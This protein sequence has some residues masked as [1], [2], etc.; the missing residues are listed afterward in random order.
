MAYTVPQFRLFQD[1]EESTAASTSSLSAVIIAPQYNVHQYNDGSVPSYITSSDGKKTQYNPEGIDS[2]AYPNKTFGSQVDTE[3]VHI[4]FENAPAVYNSFSIGSAVSDATATIGGE[5]SNRIST[6]KVLHSGNGFNAPVEYEIGDRVVIR[7]S[8]SNTTPINAEI[9]GF[10]PTTVAAVV[11]KPVVN[12]KGDTTSTFALTDDATYTGKKAT[13]YVVVFSSDTTVATTGSNNIRY[14]VYDTAN[15][16][17]ARMYTSDSNIISIGSNGVSVNISAGTISAGTTLIIEVSPE[18]DGRYTDVLVNTSLDK[19]TSGKVEL[20]RNVTFELSSSYFSA[21]RDAIAIGANIKIDGKDIKGGYIAVEYRERVNSFV[22]RVGSLS[23]STEVEK[24]LGVISSDNPL[25]LMVYQALL[26]S[27][28]TEVYFTAV[29]TDD[30]AGYTDALN[31]IDTHNEIYSLVP[32]STDYT[33][34][35][36]IRSYIEE[37]ST[38]TRVD[39]KIG[40]FGCDVPSASDVLNTLVDGSPLLISVSGY[41]AT[42]QGIADITAIS[43]GDTVTITTP[44]KKEVF[45]VD[46]IISETSFRVYEGVASESV[47]AGTAVVTHRNTASEIADKVSAKSSRFNNERVR[48][49]Y[50]DGI[51]PSIDINTTGLSNAY[52]AAAC[53]GLRSASAP[54]QPLTRAELSGFKANPKYVFSMT[55]LNDMAENGTWLVINDDTTVYVRHQLTTK[56]SSENYNLREDS[57]V[58]NADEISRTYRDGLS[59]YYGRANI[60]PEFIKYIKTVIDDISYAISV[61]EYPTSLGPQILSYQPSDVSQSP[62]LSDALIARVHIDTPEPLNYFDVYLTIQ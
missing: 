9:I 3:S 44:D 2:A 48:S 1:F 22:G 23:S 59:D 4:Y 39:W 52:V 15:T 5:S 10:M 47:V 26:N 56:S 55:N 18:R 27:N 40:W 41:E 25:A 49:V 32:Y 42:I 7:P 8:G 57:K 17:P 45:T 31:T 37:R 54:H 36:I 11:K 53:A 24:E 29:A 12:Y 19:V 35:D 43:P 34:Q 28:G 16:E 14:S 21:E 60:S 38:P 61:R 13:A 20:C 58:T 33:V 6:N 30:V 51:I 46:Y 50:A 62:S